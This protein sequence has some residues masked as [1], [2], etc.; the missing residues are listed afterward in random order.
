M[1]CEEKDKQIKTMHDNGLGE[2]WVD[3]VAEKDKRIEE[4]EG[5]QRR[6]LIRENYYKKEYQMYK[7]SNFKWKNE[8]EFL[9]QRLTDELHLER[10]LLRV[11]EFN[12]KATCKDYSQAFIEE[13]KS[14]KSK[15]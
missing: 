10:V 12:R 6:T 11:F 13:F 4:L 5:I 8:Y 2:S 15:K 1:E 3:R 7:D 9:K 14:K